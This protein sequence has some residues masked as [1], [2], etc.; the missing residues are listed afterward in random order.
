MLNETDSTPILE[1]RGLTVGRAGQAPVATEAALAA[2][3]GEII[4][5]SGKSGV[6]KT[7]LLWALAR[8]VAIQDGSLFLKGKSSSVVPP[9]QWRRQV[10]LVLQNPVIV[11]GTVRCNLVLPFSLRVSRGGSL[12][13]PEEA[14]LTDLAALGLGDIGLDRPSG[15]LSG[16]EAARVAL[17][18]T[19]LTRPACLMLDEPTAALDQ[20]TCDLVLQRV[21]AFANDGGA[22]IMVRHGA[23]PDGSCRDFVLADGRLEPAN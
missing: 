2:Y 21:R 14:L 22:V 18:R 6:G 20:A 19:L 4:T 9:E 7:T 11:P 10:A 3:A 15:E 12:N 8:L 1:A 5:I 23:Q 17:L 16:G 13:W